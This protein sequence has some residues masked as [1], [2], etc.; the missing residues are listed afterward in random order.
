[1][2]K[3]EVTMKFTAIAFS[4]LL[5][6]PSFANWKQQTRETLKEYAYACPATEVVI[7]S[8]VRNDLIKGHVRGL[9]TDAYDKFKVVFYVKTNIWY[10]HPYQ[11]YPG[12]DEGYSYSNLNS[13][14][15]FQVKTVLRQVPADA[16]AAVLVPKSF[17]IRN[18]RGWLRPLFGFVGGVL[19]F[20]CSHGMVEGNG[21]F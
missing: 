4:L 9:P 10:I 1:M 19:K 3:T 15:E 11:Y 14:G 13:K 21:D 16:L 12:Q 18:Y 17:K 2:K 8:I 7:D 5:S 6:F 20:Q